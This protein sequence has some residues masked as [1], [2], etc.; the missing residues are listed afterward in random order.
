VITEVPRIAIAVRDMDR[1][2]A[3]FR[4]VLG[5]PVCEFGGVRES[6]GIRMA[7]CTPPGGSHIEL[8]APADPDRAHARS[9]H[10]YL[11]RRGEGLFAL[12]LYAP[13]PDAEAD[14]LEGRGLAA[15]APMPD[16]QG[17]D[18]HPRDACG[19]LIRIYPAG[20]A[21]AIEDE[22][23]RTLGPASDRTGEAGLSGIVRAVIAVLD[24]DRAVAVYRDRLGLDTRADGDRAV[25]LCTPP[26]GATIELRAADGDREGLHAL[27]LESDDPEL[28][29]ARLSEAGARVQRVGARWELDPADSFGARIWI[30]SAA[31]A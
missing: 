23:E 12:M 9:L 1:A 16:A 30:E 22:L 10:G 31:A 27:V 3:A 4:D 25:A 6:L 7:L 17:R 11:D 29:A 8:M 18:I 20:M 24:L 14:E 28:S 19:V 15:M 5:M 13:D 21:A 2:V 26:A